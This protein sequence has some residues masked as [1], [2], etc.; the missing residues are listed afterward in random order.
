MKVYCES[1]WVDRSTQV[2]CSLGV[3]GRYGP[4]MDT[5]GPGEAPGLPQYTTFICCYKQLKIIS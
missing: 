4:D 2:Q 5:K 3:S 1:V